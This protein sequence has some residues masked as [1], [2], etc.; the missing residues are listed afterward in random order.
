MK[1]GTYLLEF[2]TEYWMA[3]A[4]GGVAVAFQWMCK[5]QNAVRKGIQ[6]L[7]RSE[8]I[9]VYNHYYEQG[10]IPIYALENVQKMY[11]Q[12]HALGGNGA[13]TKLVE[14]LKDLPTAVDVSP[15]KS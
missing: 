6:A 7:L 12:Y 1:E 11:E 5:R 15:P 13:L 10:Y 4:F 2:I 9:T 3:A 8:I 14:D